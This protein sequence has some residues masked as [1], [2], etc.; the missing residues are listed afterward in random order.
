MENVKAHKIQIIILTLGV[1]VYKN[2][3]IFY[4]ILVTAK[5]KSQKTPFWQ[6]SLTN[7][8]V[9]GFLIYSVDTPLHRQQFN[10]LI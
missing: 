10:N 7:K 1:L 9:C 6:I 4:Y 5:K 3:N 8:N 2:V